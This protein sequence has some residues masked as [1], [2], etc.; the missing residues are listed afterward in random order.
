MARVALTDPEA[1]AVAWTAAVDVEAN[2]GLL[3]LC[4]LLPEVAAPSVS[5]R[6]ARTLSGVAGALREQWGEAGQAAAAAVD[7]MRCDHEK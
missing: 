6:E 4:V 1:P 5:L 3:T 7:A 2:Q